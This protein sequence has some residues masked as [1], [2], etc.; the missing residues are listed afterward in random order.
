ME[1]QQQP[2]APVYAA[3]APAQKSTLQVLAVPAA[4]LIGF[5]MIAAAIF[6]SGG[7][8]NA[9]A[10]LLGEANEVT[11]TD[12][13]N[14]ENINPVTAEDHIR[15]NPNAPIVIVEYSDF[16]C[17]FCKN[18]HDTMNQ[19]IAEYGTDGKVA[20]V[21]RHFPLQQ[22]HPNAPTIA[23]ASECVA[24]LAGNDGFWTFADLVFNERSTNEPTNITRL[25]E[26]AVTAGADAGA[27]TTCMEENRHIAKV[28]EDFNNALAVGGRGTPHSIIMVG[29]QQ[30][31]INGAQPYAT[32]K[33]IIDNLIAQIEGQG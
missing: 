17:P 31:V 21:Y 25:E 13:G 16:D 5:G 33:Q 1:P 7:S 19:I 10:P 27:F 18:F 30:G 4:I 6:F 20:W 29:D 28:E 22:L 2:A 9:A 23:H 14:P 12:S 8:N 32:V 3:P 11:P 15:G 24:E 26:F